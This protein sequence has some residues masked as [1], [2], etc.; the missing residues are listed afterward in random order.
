MKYLIK[1][2]S[3]SRPVNFERG[4]K[5][6]IELAKNPKAITVIVSLDIDDEAL[7]EYMTIIEKYWSLVHIK[8]KADTS[9]SKI[10]AIN[11][12]V[13]DYKGEWNILINFSDDMVFTHPYWDEFITEKFIKHFPDGDGFLH[14]NDGNQFKNICTM[15]VMD[16]KYYQRTNY[17]YNSEYISLECD[18]EA[19]D[20]AH[21][22]GRKV[23]V[24]QQIYKHL[25]H[26][27]GLAPNDR[28]YALN[29]NEAIQTK[30]L[31]TFNK[32]K[33]INY[34]IENPLNPSLYA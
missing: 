25:H 34:G 23:Y 10:H 13:N 30:D 1:Y 31:D 12:E 27:W 2:A 21:M 9:L 6:I 22:T 17:I 29:S 3:R 15:S 4:L 14:L 11:R 19:T 28:L 20:V 26:E 5:S 16:C 33:A 24:D 7:P 32:R 18:R 8:V